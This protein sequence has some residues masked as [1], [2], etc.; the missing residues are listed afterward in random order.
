MKDRK[1][2]LKCIDWG[3]VFSTVG[4]CALSAVWVNQHMLF[5]LSPS[6]GMCICTVCLY[7]YLTILERPVGRFVDSPLSPAKAW[8]ADTM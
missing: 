3:F 6:M 8:E 5:C 2:K 1:D 7:V 4:L